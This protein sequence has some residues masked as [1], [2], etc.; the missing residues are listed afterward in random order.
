MPMATLTIV[1]F[2][3]D[4]S[5]SDEQEDGE[6]RELAAPAEPANVYA[7]QSL[8]LFEDSSSQ[9]L[10]AVAAAAVESA[11]AGGTPEAAA[12]ADRL[13]R[14]ALARA[15]ADLAHAHE[16][17]A[18][19]RLR[20]GEAHASCC[21]AEAALSHANAVKAGALTS[22]EQATAHLA[23]LEQAAAQARS[24][25][26]AS[27]S[28]VVRR[29]SLASPAVPPCTTRLFVK[30]ATSVPDADD[31][32]LMQLFRAHG[33]RCAHV[34]SRPPP[35]KA[36]ASVHVAGDE[37]HAR[38]VVSATNG[39]ALGPHGR[40]ITVQLAPS[41]DQTPCSRPHPGSPPTARA[42]PDR[43]G[44]PFGAKRPR[45][46]AA[47]GQGDAMWG[48]TTAA[49]L[50]V[51]E[52]TPPAS[53]A[54]SPAAKQLVVVT[55]AAPQGAVAGMLLPGGLNG[56]ARGHQNGAVMM[57][58]PDVVRVHRVEQV[59][60]EHALA[61]AA[62]AAACASRSVSSAQSPGLECMLLCQPRN[63]GERAALNAALLDGML[64]AK[65]SHEDWRLMLVPDLQQAQA[66]QPGRLLRARLC[67]LASVRRWSELLTH[68]Q[69]AL[70][71][72][73]DETV[74]KAYR[75]CDLHELATQLHAD[76]EAA[77]AQALA[78]PRNAG[79]RSAAT[80]ASKRARTAALWF[81]Y[82]RTYVETSSCSALAMYAQPW[83]SVSPGP[84]AAQHTAY[85]VPGGLAGGLSGD[86]AL[87]RVGGEPLL[88][89][90]RPGWPLLRECLRTRFW[91]CVATH[92]SPDY[93][94]EMARLLDPGLSRVH[95]LRSG[96]EGQHSEWQPLQ[97]PPSVWGSSNGGAGGAQMQPLLSYIASFRRDPEDGADAAAPLPPLQL[98]QKSFGA[99]GKAM[100]CC[101]AFV[102]L[103]DMIGG[104]ESG[105]GVWTLSDTQRVL[106][107]PPFRPFASGEDRVM[108]HC[109]AALAAVHETF[110]QAP[111]DS[112]AAHL[113]ALVQHQEASRFPR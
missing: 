12:Q 21:A 72:D 24:A 103:D 105:A 9:E 37:Q 25:V 69:L 79:L 78:A 86:C 46:P 14:A 75:L 73:L 102:A 19:A 59:Q 104:R 54:D 94:A 30:F 22:L 67:P 81:N 92:A 58:M 6:I 2:G 60:Y 61:L 10:A 74:V 51:T 112:S 57:L 111:G 84:H 23:A 47:G 39:I 108:E 71:L 70:A 76:A 49:P 68:Q 93:A 28:A 53:P 82:L 90:L 11:E 80:D 34:Q 29:A 40:T 95:L 55:D 3:D 101:N 65:S 66:Q 45:L 106:C 52:W 109:A 62:D 89:C 113:A 38:A 107:P 7:S 31:E 1:P 42:S 43:N 8:P 33:A 63:E 97:V 88:V 87:V 41:S 13:S 91:T 16:S 56:E 64:S 32:Q 35:K 48:H 44:G 26:Q 20:V 18:A 77:R 85:C 5:S 36:F 98:I 27:A 100:P 15:E 83:S 17:V 50:K 99:L 96:G 110:F 4:S